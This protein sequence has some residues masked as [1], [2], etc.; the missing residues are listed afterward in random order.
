MALMKKCRFTFSGGSE[1]RLS[2]V[3][4]RVGEEE[5]KKFQRIP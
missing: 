1:V 4:E 5:M 3:M 2:E